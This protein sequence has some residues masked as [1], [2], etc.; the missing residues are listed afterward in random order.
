MNVPSG[1]PPPPPGLPA[2][3][4]PPSS[5]SALGG[6]CKFWGTDQGCRRGDR[7]QHQHNW[8]GLSKTNRCFGRSGRGHTKRE[9]P[10]GRGKDQAT[11]GAARTQKLAKTKSE[12]DDSSVKGHPAGD[13]AKGVS[14][15]PAAK[16]SNGPE[17]GGDRRGSSTSAEADDPSRQL[18][19]KAANLLKT[20]RSMKAMKLKSLGSEDGTTDGWALLDGG[21]THGL[22]KAR[23]DEL[24]HLQPVQVEL[25]SG[26]TTLYRQ[27]DEVEPLIPLRA[28]VEQGFQIRWNS[29]GCVIRSSSGRRLECELR[30]GGD[31]AA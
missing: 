2:E 14:E 28:L 6:V 7:C 13:E 27:R 18:I 20:L 5:S 22:R 19:Q 1:A 8:K 4:P 15:A 30:Q 25:A 24:P 17:Q 23:Q 26:S 12:K 16:H 3:K 31:E 29:K 21:A 11:D 10:A 9:C